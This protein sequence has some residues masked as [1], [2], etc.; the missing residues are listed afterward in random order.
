MQAYTG[1]AN[2]FISYAQTGK[3]GDMVAA[4]LD[5]G[6]DH[7]RCVWIDIFAIRQWPSRTPD[8]DFASTIENCSSF[9]VVR[10]SQEAVE[11]M[12]EEDYIAGRSELLPSE[13]RRQICFMRVWCLVETHKA[14]SM[15]NMP[16]IL[17]GGSHELT[18][19]A[20]IVKFIPNT[21]MLEKV[22]FLVNAEK[23]EATVASDK[24]HILQGIRDGV[25][26]EKLNSAIRGSI[27]GA[28]GAA[29]IEDG[30]TIQCAACGDA[31][32][33]QNVLAKKSSILGF[34]CGGYI[35]LLEKLLSHDDVNVEE[36]TDNQGMTSLMVASPGGHVVCIEVMWS[37]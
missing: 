9:L 33:L 10:S 36:A 22:V 7:N 11:D 3:R 15:P 5:G 6:A 31:E 19:D 4:I 27:S 8:L 29:K 23:V 34:S 13:V 24:E 1:Q 12:I 30:A 18:N 28:C 25:G 14:C 32:A 20:S 17:K 21:R 2:T 35:G 26:I 37:V 16:Y